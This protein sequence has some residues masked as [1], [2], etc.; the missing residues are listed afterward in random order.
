MTK[1]IANKAKLVISYGGDNH[2]L[3]VSHFVD[4]S[5]TLGINSDSHR[6]EGALT[7]ITIQD[8]NN[9]NEILNEK[10]KIEE[11]PRLKVEVNG[12]D[13]DTLCVS[14]IFIGE[15]YRFHMSRLMIKH[16][17]DL[18]EQKGSGLIVTTGAGSTG[19]YN[20][21]VRFLFPDEDIFPKTSKEARF[22]L[23]EPYHGK[24][25]A[26]KNVKG[27]IKENEVLEITSSCELS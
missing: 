16:N 15:K 17:N 10:F 14:E 3:F 8:L 13:I 25:L 21:A 18:I 27:K 11:W 19:W 1:E 9:P 24:L 26:A 22:L 23:S 5:L 7:S 2:F 12:K 4:N 20:S 6:S